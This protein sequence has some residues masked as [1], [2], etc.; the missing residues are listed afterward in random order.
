MSQWHMNRMGLVDFWCYENDEFYFSDGHMLLR[1]SNGSGKSVT[2]QS[3]IPLLLDGNKSSERLDPFGT[4]SRKIETYLIDENSDRDNRI[5]YLYL[6]FKR[7]DSDMYKTIGMGLHARKNKPLDTWYFVVEDNKR[8]NIDFQLIENKLT[9]TMKQLQNILG[10]QVFKGQKEYMKRVNNALFGYSN[11][12]D[13]KDAIDLLLQLRSPKLSNSLSPS[14]INELLATSLQPLSDDDLR[15]MS[16]AIVSMDNLQDELE[17]LNTSL[18]AANKIYKAYELYNRVILLDKWNKYQREN[19]LYINIEKVIKEKNIEIE[20]IEKEYLIL[21]EQYTNNQVQL[22]IINKEKTILMD[23]KME[24]LHEELMDLKQQVNDLQQSISVKEN[25]K[26]IKENRVIDLNKDIEKYDNNIYKHEKIIQQS[27]SSLNEIYTTFPFSEHIALKEALEN[28]QEFQFDY[29]KKRIKE[30]KNNTTQLLSLYNTYEQQL[31]IIKNIEDKMIQLDEQID[32]LNSELNNYK[33]QYEQCINEYQEYFY[34]YSKHNQVLKLSSEQLTIMTD[35]LLD[36]ELTNDYH[37]IYN[38]VQQ[39]YQNQYQLLTNNKTLLQL[40]LHK[41][42]DNYNNI[43]QEYN[44]LLN[45]KDFEPEREDLISKNRKYLDEHQIPYIPL[46][47]LLDF[48]ENMSEEDKNI[49]EELLSQMKI[50]DAIVIEKHHK[51][52]IEELCDKG[53]DY[54]LWTNSS[55]NDLKTQV[56]KEKINTIHLYEILDQLY[57]EYNQNLIINH[58]YFISGIIQGNID[59][60]QHAS[61]IG[62][63][64]RQRLRQEKIELLKEKLEMTENHISKI[65]NDIKNIEDNVLVL[66]TE[67]KQFKD[68]TDLKDIYLNIDKKNREIAYS[69]ENIDQYLIQK[70]EEER[71]SEE[72]LYSIKKECELLLLDVSK[73]SIIYRIE[74]IDEYESDIDILKGSIVEKKHLNQLKDIEK[75]K[76][77]ELIDDIDSLKNELFVAEKQKKT[78]EGNIVV[79]EKQLEEKGYKD[80]QKRL[81]EIEKTLHNLETDNQ[82]NLIQSSKLEE[83]K[84]NIKD[85]LKNETLKLNNQKDIKEQYYDILIQEINYHFVFKENDEQVLKELKNMSKNFNFTKSISEYQGILQGVFFENV[86]YLSQYHLT[87]QVDELCIEKDDVNGH[88]MIFA[89]PVGK[90][91]PFIELLEILKQRIETQKLL[92]VEEDRHIFEEILVNTIGRKIR[93]RIQASKR[94]VEKMERYMKDMNTS[95]GLQLSLKWRSK[96]ANDDDEL[97]TAQL[98]KLLEIDYRLL[99]EEDR[100]KISQHFRSKIETARRISSDDNTTASFHQLIKEVMDYRKWFEFTLYTQKTNEN[101]KE[102]TNRLFY[103]YSGGEKAISM[104]VPLFSAVAAKYEGARE[105]APHLIALDEA[106]A[107]VDTNNIDNMFAL[108]TKFNFDYIMNSQVLWGD[109]P[110]CKSLAIYELFRPDNAP[111]VTKVAYQWNGSV[112]KVKV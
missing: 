32:L 58:S 1:G 107:G 52:V 73:Q 88:F 70:N 94:W 3:F 7:E 10:D 47:K 54:Y 22:E 97:D 37:S 85:S 104:Y 42:Q 91:I 98:V 92:I 109:Y 69:K 56:I 93:N 15:P 105:D 8:V 41:K 80:K 40:E 111:F 6:E 24:R 82:N 55:L 2:M 108:I 79:I 4:R 66:D 76:L 64:R 38:I 65:K 72:I 44:Q 110:S 21:K 78:H 16:E 99:K 23:P 95:S 102:L 101:K 60:K 63:N 27:L 14:K 19:S 33:K 89:S 106:F 48:D 74:C 45:Q 25:Q 75:E 34:N 13:Y 17:T 26:E 49:S 11:I 12:E 68:E 86:A 84:N 50:L 18:D 28:H 39:Q 51:K 35:N 96:K 67:L 83:R 43:A 20:N 59:T 9:L 103:S 77:D 81:E 53:H 71:K 57:I 36:Y 46:F 90:K 29:T 5:G 87:H 31:L 112:R 61:Y 100:N 62:F 30:E